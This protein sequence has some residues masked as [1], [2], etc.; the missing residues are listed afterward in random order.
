V[1]TAGADACRVSRQLTTENLSDTPPLYS[2]RLAHLVLVPAFTNARDRL[3]D[4]LGP[5]LA[6]FLVSALT[7]H[8]RL[9][10]SSPHVRT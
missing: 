4:A 5:E 3:D 9:G 8:G 6:R 2:R 7:G 10:S 1:G